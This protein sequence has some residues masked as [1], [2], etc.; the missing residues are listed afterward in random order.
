M[1]AQNSEILARAMRM[2]KAM[3][4]TTPDGRRA[5]LFMQDR[6]GSS[7]FEEF[8][9]NREG[10]HEPVNAPAFRAI[11]LLDLAPGDGTDGI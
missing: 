1:N 5:A 2:V 10:S 4:A 8:V 3:D 9:T 6:N 7:L 11:D